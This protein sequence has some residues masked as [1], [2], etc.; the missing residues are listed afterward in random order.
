M[1]ASTYVIDVVQPGHIDDP[2]TGEGAV[3]LTIEG[4]VGDE[5]LVV[6][7]ALSKR[8]ASV[9]GMSSDEAED[10]FLAGLRA[11]KAHVDGLDVVVGS[12][13]HRVRRIP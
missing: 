8:S 1:K 2:A 4:A 12:W 3:R 7:E 6:V 11:S 13:H 5:V 9:C 10:A